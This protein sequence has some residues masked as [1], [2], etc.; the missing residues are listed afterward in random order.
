MC[1]TFS[2]PLNELRDENL[3][4]HSHTFLL[5]TVRME[6]CSGV[7]HYWSK[8]T[9]AT[10]WHPSLISSKSAQGS[11]TTVIC[12]HDTT[13][14]LREGANQITRI[15]HVMKGQ[16]LR[17]QRCPALFGNTNTVPLESTSSTKLCHKIDFKNAF[18]Y[19]DRF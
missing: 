5:T 15:C 9:G 8:G 18:G 12:V 7:W 1:V 14:L 13:S 16:R 2:N 19:Y 10:I 17:R 3:S 4:R 6:G 11:A